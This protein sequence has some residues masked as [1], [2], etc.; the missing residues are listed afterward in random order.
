ML[1]GRSSSTNVQ[2]LTGKALLV[3]LLAGILV[4]VAMAVAQPAPHAC[5]VRKAM[6]GSAAQI[7]DAGCDMRCCGAV[8]T[9]AT[10]AVGAVL[11]RGA[12]EVTCSATRTECMEY[13]QPVSACHSGRAP[14]VVIYS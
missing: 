12:T 9:T 6:Q 7:R 14:P 3:F 4:P 13:F 8:S 1:V 2:R 5:C 11:A 10:A